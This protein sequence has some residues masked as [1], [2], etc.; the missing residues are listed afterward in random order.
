MSMVSATD[1]AWSAAGSKSA[2]ML[3]YYRVNAKTGLKIP[4]RRQDK[5]GRLYSVVA[6]R[7]KPS[8]S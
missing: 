3:R 7:R 6:R 1:M 2:K 4:S 5:Y 8:R